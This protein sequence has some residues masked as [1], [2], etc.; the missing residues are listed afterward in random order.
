MSGSSLAPWA[1]L[2]N[3]LNATRQLARH[4][5]C[6]P[7]QSTFLPCLRSKPLTDILAAPITAPRFLPTFG[8]S[9][10]GIVISDEFFMSRAS[11]VHRL[12]SY[13]LMAGVTPADAADQL[14]ERQLTAG[15]TSAERDQILR[16]YTQN[17][18]SFHLNELVSVIRHDYTDWTRGRP[19]PRRVRD[20]L[21]RA[22][23]DAQFVAPMAQTASLF[24]DDRGT[25]LYVFGG[26]GSQASALEVSVVCWILI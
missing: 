9:L 17:S 26:H 20:E 21:V 4:T 23:G 22:L 19:Q 8:P 6:S 13:S 15:V 1:L 24:P 2:S 14:S 16:T 11:Y 5:N 18:Y 12:V 10:D 3:P 7:S 25:Y